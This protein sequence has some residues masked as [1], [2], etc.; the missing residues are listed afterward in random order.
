MARSYGGIREFNRIIIS[1]LC[2]QRG[3]VCFKILA[4]VKFKNSSICS[5][6]IGLFK[7]N[8]NMMMYL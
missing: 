3:V 5:L 6:I 7:T 1:F 8:C 4:P 2:E